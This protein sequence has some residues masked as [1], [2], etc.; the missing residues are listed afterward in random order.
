[1][2]T[3]SIPI[4]LMQGYFLR[5][6]SRS[7]P[8]RLRE[9]TGILEIGSNVIPADTKNKS[10][11]ILKTW[12]QYQSNPVPLEVFE[13]WKALGLFVY[14]IAVVTGNIWRG[15]NAGLCLNLI[16]GDNRIALE[17]C[18]YKGKT[19]SLQQFASWTLVEQHKDNPNRGHI[20]I[21]STKP[22]PIKAGDKG[23]IDSANKI[24]A[25]QIPG[26]EVKNIG[27]LSFAWNSIH[28]GGYRYEFLNGL[29]NATLCDDFVRHIDSICKKYNLRY[30]DEN[31]TGVGDIPIQELFMT[32]TIIYEG[33]NRH[34]QV[35]RASDSLIKRLK[36]IF[37]S[38]K[39]TSNGI[40]QGGQS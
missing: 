16:D 5:R 12:K 2:T 18:T 23:S 27:G 24:V 35:L 31:G 25:N 38:D 14:G 1:M 30:L 9:F 37:P 4:I 20:Y 36:G 21:L 33:N 39:I 34:K 13:R 29:S 26:I 22:F 10:P 19:V 11:Y 15:K 17:I 8:I 28:E 40:Q 7:E 3:I 32:D 6:I